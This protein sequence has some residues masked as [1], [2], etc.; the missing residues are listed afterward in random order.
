MKLLLVND[1][2]EPVACLHDVEGYDAHDSSKVFAMLDLL[3][4][5]IA[6]A[7][8]DETAAGPQRPLPAIRAGSQVAA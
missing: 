8:E 6:T 5:M 2:G 4:R 1:S 7:K 3:E